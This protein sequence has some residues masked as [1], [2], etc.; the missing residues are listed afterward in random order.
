MRL[1]RNSL[2]HVELVGEL[3]EAV[4][5]V[6]PGGSLMAARGAKV[7]MTI[8]REIDS[9]GD[10][11]IAFL[12]REGGKPGDFVSFG[13]RHV[14]D[15]SSMAQEFANKYGLKVVRVGATKAARGGSAAKIEDAQI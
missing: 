10:Y 5:P 1:V 15:V 12:K 9:H 4:P 2:G 14:K 8:D 13:S 11:W 3:D 6:P 7:S